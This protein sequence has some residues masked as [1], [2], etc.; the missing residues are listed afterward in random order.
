MEAK[1]LSASQ[2]ETA[3]GHQFIGYGLR[4]TR[5][6]RMIFHWFPWKSN[7]SLY[8]SFDHS[9]LPGI[10]WVIRILSYLVRPPWHPAYPGAFRSASTCSSGVSRCCLESSEK[11]SYL[12]GTP[13]VFQ[14]FKLQTS[15]FSVPSTGFL[16]SWLCFG[17]HQ[18]KPWFS[19]RFSQS[20]WTSEDSMLAALV[21][22]KGSSGAGAHFLM[23]I[24]EHLI[25]TSS[26]LVNLRDICWTW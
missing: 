18:L 8:H 1:N 12:A 13:I 4:P 6:V 3:R 14:G 9:Q 21:L 15:C 11:P 26:R 16:V 10:K 23:D 24:W 17:E 19:S 22:P 20:E 25:A 2:G 7:G 5:L